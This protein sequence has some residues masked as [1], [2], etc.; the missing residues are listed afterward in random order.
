M[1]D[2]LII[3]LGILF[4]HWVSDF[5]LQTH[6]MATNKSKNINALVSHVVT[7]YLSMVFL[8]GLV[9]Y[10]VYGA[11]LG[12]WGLMT[13]WW[14]LNGAL[15]F[16]VDFVTSRITAKLWAKG[17]MHNFFVMVGLDQFLHYA[18][19]FGTASWMLGII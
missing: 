14:I 13:L 3:I 2:Q 19:L 12:L 4:S 9:F 1:S 8:T 7:Y 6:W 11:D 18:C 17:D 15:H 5:V 10:Y 16:C